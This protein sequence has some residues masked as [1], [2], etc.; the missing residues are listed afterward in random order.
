MS[1]R[2]GIDI[3]GII[4][5]CK[6]YKDSINSLKKLSSP[7]EDQI[8]QYAV[9]NNLEMI[10]TDKWQAKVTITP[11]QEFNEAK[12]VDILKA[13]LPEEI[14]SSCIKTK[15]YIDEDALEKLIYNGT[16]NEDLLAC[17]ITDKPA[18]IRLTINQ[19]KD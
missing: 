18:T 5:Q 11:N 9:S 1:R 8:K 3:V 15:E 13:E 4:D 2:D 12:A 19:R 16:I 6:E 10:K 17:C 7:L 14:Y